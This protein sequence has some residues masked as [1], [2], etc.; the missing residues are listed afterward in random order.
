MKIQSEA[1]RGLALVFKEDGVGE[2][3]RWQGQFSQYCKELEAA[4]GDPKIR[5]EHGS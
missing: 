1:T 4:G 5:E 3:V 2:E